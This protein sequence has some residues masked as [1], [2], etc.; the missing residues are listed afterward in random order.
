MARDLPPLSTLRA[1]DAAAQTL[2]FSRA[3]QDL[4]LTHGAVSRAVRTLED[5]L[6]VSLFDRSGRS[7]TLTP[8]GQI[9]AQEVRHA[10]GHLRAAAARI[11]AE[12]EQGVLG[13]TTMDSFAVKWLL[14]RAARFRAAH[15]EID[16]RLQVTDELIDFGR[17]EVDIAVRY[18]SGGYK[19]LEFEK[20]MDEDVFPVCSPALLSGPHPLRTPADLVHHTLIHDDMRIDWAA[21]LAAAGVEG[22]DARRGP[23]YNL[24]SYVLQAAIDGQGVALGRGALVS[25]DLRAG[26]LVKPFAVTLP[27]MFSYYV[28]CPKGALDRPKVKAFRDW[29][30][31]EAARDRDDAGGQDGAGLGRPPAV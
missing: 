28:V 13:V 8:A 1:F 9:Y 24:S 23:A 15:P 18:G 7:V 30:F 25:D 16:L 27:A 5:H 14:P 29:L 17:H 6:G 2:S 10:L 20:L 22:V 11:E 3:A 19:G 26:R 4:F 21:W 12:R 31:E